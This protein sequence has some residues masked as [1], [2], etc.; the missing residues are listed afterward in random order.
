MS[1]GPMS[2]ELRENKVKHLPK[3]GLALLLASAGA[4][5]NADFL[6]WSDA[7]HLSAFQDTSNLLY[8]STDYKMNLWHSGSD[9]IYID[10][11]Q[12]VGDK[13]D[14]A[15]ASGSLEYND[16]LGNIK[17]YTFGDAATGDFSWSFDKVA[18]HYGA[19]LAELGLHEFTMNV[20]GR[21]DDGTGISDP[22]ILQSFNFTYDV[23]GKLDITVTGNVT[24]PI[25]HAGQTTGV[26]MT[27]LNNMDRDFVSTSWFTSAIGNGSGSYLTG[28]FDHSYEWFNR[29]IGTGQSLT[30]GHSFW[31]ADSSNPDGIYTGDLGVVGGLYNGDWHFVSMN[32]APQ[33]TVQSVPGPASFLPMAIGLISIRARKR[34]R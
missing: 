24:N 8:S 12:F 34:R 22:T 7:D 26:D 33:I 20:W 18:A 13:G 23:A 3:T 29:T 10:D 15:A 6:F 19:S 2:D 4:L 31:W 32:P 21:T 9:V 28:D 1:Q 27:V 30:G 5:S 11:L 14:L 25:I 17:T 16:G